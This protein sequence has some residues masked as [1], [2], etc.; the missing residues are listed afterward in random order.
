[1]EGEFTLQQILKFQAGHRQEIYVA[2]SSQSYFVISLASTHR[3]RQVCCRP[4][5]G[6]NE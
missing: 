5:Y 6:F 4:A 1:M 2:V 3:N